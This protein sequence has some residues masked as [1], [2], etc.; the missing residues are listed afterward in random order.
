MLKLSRIDKSL[1]FNGSLEWLTAVVKFLAT[2]NGKPIMSL[3]VIK[4]H[5]QAGSSQ[6]GTFVW[7]SPVRIIEPL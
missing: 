6:S 4:Q 2:R 7:L 3:Y 1:G 5:N